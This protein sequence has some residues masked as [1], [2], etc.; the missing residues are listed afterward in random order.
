MFIYQF[1]YQVKDFDQHVDVE[2]VCDGI[3]KY[4]EADQSASSGGEEVIQVDQH[5][6]GSKGGMIKDEEADQPARSGDEEVIKI[7]QPSICKKGGMMKVMQFL[8]HIRYLL[9]Q[10]YLRTRMLINLY[11][12][13]I[14]K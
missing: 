12:I 14:T 1:F 7:D 9:Y 8:K 4:K 5:R 10:K 2:Y 6:I 3:I 11:F 13:M